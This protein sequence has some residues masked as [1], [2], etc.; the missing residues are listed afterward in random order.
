[1]TLPWESEEA[2]P[3]AVSCLGCEFIFESSVQGD[4]AV[5]RLWQLMAYQMLLFHGRYPG[6]EPLTTFDRLPLRSA[7]WD[8]D[9][10]IEFLMLAPADASSGTH[11]FESGSFE[12]LRVV[13]IT[14]KEASFARSNGGDALLEFLRGQSAFPVTDPTRCSVDLSQPPSP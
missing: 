4:W 7:I 1:M 12:L 13:G 9:S 2:D 8:S 3:S 11:K 6:R 5:R 10:E 14:E